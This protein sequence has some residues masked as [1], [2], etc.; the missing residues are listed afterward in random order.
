M[1][2]ILEQAVRTAPGASDCWALLSCT[3][4]A[5]FHSDVNVR[6]DPLGRAIETAHRAVDT[7]PTNQIAHYALALARFYRKERGAF[8]RTDY[9][10]RWWNPAIYS[11]PVALHPEMSEWTRRRDMPDRRDFVKGVA[12]ATAGMLLGRG[13]ISDAAVG[14]LQTAAAP[15]RRQVTIG[16][17]RIQT[18]DIH[19]HVIVP[20]VADVLKGTLLA[21]SGGA[22]SGSGTN[23]VMSP[24]WLGVMDAQGIDIRVLSINPFW[25]KADRNLSTRL[26]ALQNDKLAEMCAAH[27]DRFMPLAAVSLQHPD[28]AAQELEDAHRKHD[29]RGA[30]IGCS[31]EGAELSDP[32][33]DPFWAKARELGMLIFLHPQNSA[34]ATGAAA[35]LRG[36][37]FLGNV[38][39]N[40]LETTIALSH[41]IFEGTLDKFPT[42]KL[43]AAHGGGY[44]PSYA[45]RSDHGCVTFPDQCKGMTL[46]KHP[47]EYLKQISVDSVVFTP[48]GL[49]HLVA[50]VGVGHVV[51]GTDYP[52]PWVEAPV[53]HVLKTPGLT[54]ADRI[55]IL[56]GTASKLLGILPLPPTKA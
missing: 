53:D 49:R 44:L 42:L 6:P 17:R 40:P 2:E 33:F 39:G 26:M 45:D 4:S 8:R 18:V 15:R 16:G 13:G 29:M 32:K 27:P 28:L 52:F 20:E 22:G 48:E 24:E 50:V 9:R 31:V 5:E 51:V 3:Y 37:G 1:R 19:S 11:G 34:S 25:Y 56:G 14:A 23:Q 7:A 36:F 46:K 38:I 43:C 21:E 10:P 47:T 35:R 41:L 12:T 54:D 30:A 55:A